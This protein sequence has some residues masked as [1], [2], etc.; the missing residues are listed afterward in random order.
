MLN[1]PACD[2]EFNIISVS[3]TASRKVSL[4]VPNLWKCRLLNTNIFARVL[5][6]VFALSRRK[7]IKESVIAGSR[8][9]LYVGFLNTVSLL[10][11]KWE[12]SIKALISSCI[13]I[14]NTENLRHVL[15]V[16]GTENNANLYCLRA[17]RSA[18]TDSFRYRILPAMS[19]STFRQMIY[20]GRH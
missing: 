6:S 15:T 9:L 8:K 11:F 19:D 20:N 12:S 17:G 7:V 16:D 18:P 4:F 13:N 1:K 3:F 2:A 5:I 14:R 10:L